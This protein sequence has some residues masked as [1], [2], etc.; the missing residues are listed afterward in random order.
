M[1]IGEL[2]KILSAKVVNQGEAQEVKG[3]YCGDFLSHVMAKAP[4]NAAWFTIMSNVN[5]A[6]V[7]HLTG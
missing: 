5:V 4:E 2:A 7:A 3:G 6:A 1:K